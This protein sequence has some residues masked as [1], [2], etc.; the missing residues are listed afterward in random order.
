ML[1]Q[2][3]YSCFLF[4]GILHSADSSTFPGNRQPFLEKE[5]TNSVRL[6]YSSLKKVEWICTLAEVS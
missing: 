5:T 3:G 1:M 4:V 6:V 2:F